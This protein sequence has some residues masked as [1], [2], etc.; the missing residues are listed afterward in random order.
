M[1]PHWSRMIWLCSG[2]VQNSSVVDPLICP[3]GI[4]MLQYPLTAWP[5]FT[6]VV[7][8][9]NSSKASRS[10]LS[11]DPYQHKCSLSHYIFKGDDCRVENVF[12]VTM[13]TIWKLEKEKVSLNCKVNWQYSMHKEEEKGKSNWHTSGSWRGHP[14]N[15]LYMYFL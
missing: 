15:S 2:H 8:H 14:S 13:R 5:T 1:T 9:G 3:L 6:A 12:Y 4:P 7:H 10:V 11:S